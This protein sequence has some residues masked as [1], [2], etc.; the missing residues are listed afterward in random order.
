MVGNAAIAKGIARWRFFG[1]NFAQA[2]YC[3]VDDL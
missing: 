1:L 2:P 3:V